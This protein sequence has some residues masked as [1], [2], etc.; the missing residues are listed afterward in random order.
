MEFDKTEDAYIEQKVSDLITQPQI[1]EVVS[2]YERTSDDDAT[3]FEVDVNI[4]HSAKTHRRVPVLTWM[5]GAI[6][7]PSTGDYV[8]VL[9]LDSHMDSEYPVVLGHVP[10]DQNRPPKGKAGTFRVTRDDLYVEMDS[11]GDAARIAKK[12]DD[13]DTPS[14]TV[15]VDDSGDA[16]VVTIEAEGDVVINSSNGNVIL[17]GTDGQPVARKGDPVSVDD[18]D[19]GTLTGQID[20]GSTNVDAS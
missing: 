9:Y 15:E 16:T 17:G 8:L 5:A 19:S 12:P 20:D 18:P 4:H 13:M 11:D 10:T 7:P 6:H 2:V 14:S 3:N 1:G